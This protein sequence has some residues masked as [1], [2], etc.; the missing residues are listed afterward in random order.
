MKVMIKR[1]ANVGIKPATAL[2]FCLGPGCGPGKK[3]SMAGFP[4]LCRERRRGLQV[5]IEIIDQNWLTHLYFVVVLALLLITCT[6]KVQPSKKA[7]GRF[8]RFD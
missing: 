5:G 1:T 3:L 8:G 2:P 6:G 4:I 7:V